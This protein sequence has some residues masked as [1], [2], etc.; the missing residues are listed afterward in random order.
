MAYT[1]MVRDVRDR[2]CKELR[3]PKRK[4]TVRAL[5]RDD[6][7][8]CCLGVLCDIEMDD[9]WVLKGDMYAVDDATANLPWALRDRIGLPEDAESCL[10]LMNDAANLTFPEIA[11]WIEKNL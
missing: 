5:H 9:W 2:W 11:D 3:D 10:V 8:M 7:T 1:P 6:G 4:Q